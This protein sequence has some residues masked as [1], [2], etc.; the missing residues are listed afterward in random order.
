MISSTLI[1]YQLFTKAEH[2]DDYDGYYINNQVK[3]SIKNHPKKNI[4]QISSQLEASS[5]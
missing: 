4:R 2:H 3:Q 5:L 1:L